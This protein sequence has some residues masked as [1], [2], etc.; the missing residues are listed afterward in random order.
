[1]LINF[2]LLCDESD[3]KTRF[4]GI[5]H[6]YIKKEHRHIH[7]QERSNNSYGIML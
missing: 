6:F 7:V 3:V 5:E 4:L 1:M 2:L